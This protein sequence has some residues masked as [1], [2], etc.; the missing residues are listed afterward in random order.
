MKVYTP[1]FSRPRPRAKGEVDHPDPNGHF[2][3]DALTS[4]VPSLVI[5][6][7]LE[8][9]RSQALILTRKP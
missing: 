4:R 5:K 3:G 9:L 1:G 8:C 6:V 7:S 2:D